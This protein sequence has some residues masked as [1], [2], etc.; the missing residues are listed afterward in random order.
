MIAGVAIALWIG[1]VAS[2]AAF[3]AGSG[4]AEVHRADPPLSAGRHGQADVRRDPV[5]P[6]PQ[7]R[8]SL[9]AVVT[10]PRPHQGVLDGVFRVEDRP[11]HPIAVAGQL[12]PVSLQLEL[13]RCTGHHAGHPTEKFPGAGDEL[14]A[15]AWSTPQ[16]IDTDIEESS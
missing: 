10:A 6:G 11:Q 13:D 14:P 12:V 5:Q 16:H 2:W 8:A 3:E 1:G 4:R 7:S 15:S 9:E